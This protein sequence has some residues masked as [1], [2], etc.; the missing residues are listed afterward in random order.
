MPQINGIITEILPVVKGESQ[1][2]EWQRGGFVVEYGNEYPRKAAFTIFGEEKLAM[3][4]DKQQGMLVSV[5]FV[6]ESREFNGRWYTDLKAM[7][8]SVYQPTVAQG[9][10]VA[11]APAPTAMPKENESDLPF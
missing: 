2:G 8:A 4:K 7:R 9:A 6:P 5:T 10:T 3:L 11:A 1:R